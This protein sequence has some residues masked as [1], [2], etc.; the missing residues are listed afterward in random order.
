MKPGGPTIR[1]K[2]L[3]GATGILFLLLLFTGL[4]LGQIA[5]RPGDNAPAPDFAAALLD[6]ELIH[7]ASA[8]FIGLAGLSFLWFIHTLRYTLQQRE[9][10][11]EPL[12]GLVFTAGTLWGLMWLLAAQFLTMAVG[13]AGYYEHPAGAKT[14]FILAAMPVNEQGPLL[15]AVLVGATA[16]ALRRTPAFPRWY[17]QMS[18]LLAPL[19]LIGSGLSV[20]GLAFPVLPL[21]F[22]FF[23]LWILTTSILLFRQAND[24]GVE[25]SR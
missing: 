12:S 17:G 19:L 2:R 3:E 14:L 20:V 6:N 24:R 16:L 15:P 13:L 21:S 22:L 8:W 9:N 18:L 4:I 5:N 23:F 1:W 25:S 11:V 7:S 10:G